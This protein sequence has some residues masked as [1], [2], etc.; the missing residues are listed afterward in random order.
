MAF[1]VIGG[2]AYIKMPLLQYLILSYK[3]FIV[4]LLMTSYNFGNFFLSFFVAEL[5][6]SHHTICSNKLGVIFIIEDI[7]RFVTSDFLVSIARR[8]TYIIEVIL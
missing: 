3:V 8:F 2:T 1:A 4:A 5:V 7:R 6:L